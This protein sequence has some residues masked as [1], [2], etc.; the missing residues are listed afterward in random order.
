M[1]NLYENYRRTLGQLPIVN[2]TVKDFAAILP[3]V[4]TELVEEAIANTDPEKG[5]YMA[6]PPIRVKRGY[7]VVSYYKYKKTPRLDL[8][9]SKR[10]IESYSDLKAHGDVFYESLFEDE[11]MNFAEKNW[12]SRLILDNWRDYGTINLQDPSK[13]NDRGYPKTIRIIN[14]TTYRPWNDLFNDHSQPISI[15]WNYCLAQYTLDSIEGMELKGG[16]GGYI[17][18][19]CAYCGHGLGLTSCEGC[20][21]QFRDNHFRSGPAPDLPKKIV[22]FLVSN[23]HQFEKMP[24]YG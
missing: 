12:G 7:L 20:G 9:F 21:H 8:A 22:K 2:P 17:E 14:F 23:G 1:S 15:Q 18:Y 19:N 4:S 3:H 11:A 24:L 10:T 13:L 5:L 6:T 16:R